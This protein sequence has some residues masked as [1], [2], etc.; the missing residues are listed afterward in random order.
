MEYFYL[1]SWHSR[2]M[3]CSLKFV[4]HW[5]WVSFSS[6]FTGC[7]FS[8]FCR[9]IRY[10]TITIPPSFIEKS[11]IFSEIFDFLRTF[12]TAK[13]I[14]FGEEWALTNFVNHIGTFLCFS[15]TKKFIYGASMKAKTFVSR[16]FTDIVGFS[17]NFS[18]W[19]FSKAITEKQTSNTVKKFHFIQ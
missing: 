18:V 11:R 17:C 3:S 14:Y 12:E 4:R 7:P 9:F 16:G 10:E 6:S 19:V 13:E 15:C 5:R 8:I 1:G 2:G